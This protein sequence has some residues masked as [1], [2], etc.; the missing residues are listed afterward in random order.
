[1][2]T[3]LAVLL[4]S[5]STDER[6]AVNVAGNGRNTSQPATTDTR[7]KGRESKYKTNGV[8][9]KKRGQK[10]E[11]KKRNSKGLRV[12]KSRSIGC[13][14]EE[15]Y[16]NKENKDKNDNISKRRNRMGTHTNVDERRKDKI[17]D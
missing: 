1:M 14:M 15:R 13:K 12:E 7:D 17:K 5:R 9:K 10:R 2:S 6:T 4:S 8:R 11:C 16:V 3:N